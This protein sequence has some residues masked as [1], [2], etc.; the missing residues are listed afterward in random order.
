MLLSQFKINIYTIII[1]I[2]YSQIIRCGDLDSYPLLHE[3]ILSSNSLYSIEDDAIGRLEILKVLYL[4]HNLLKN[5]PISLPGNLLKLYL[6]NNLLTDIN[7]R[8]LEQLYN[9]ELLDLSGNQLSYIAALPLPKLQVLNLRSTS[10]LSLSQSLVRTS[11]ILRDLY[12]ENNPIKCAD[13]LGIAE[14]ATPCREE[15]LF[16]GD[17]GEV[18]DEG[19]SSEVAAGNGVNSNYYHQFLMQNH[20][21]KCRHLRRSMV[22]R[23]AGIKCTNNNMKLNNGLESKE[24]DRNNSETQSN[25]MKLFDQHQSNKVPN[26]ATRLMTT[27]AVVTPQEAKYSILPKAIR[28]NDND[29]KIEIHTATTSIPPTDRSITNAATTITSSTTTT[30]IPTDSPRS[31]EPEK[32]MTSSQ[33][34]FTT[35]TITH[36]QDTTPHPSTA[37][38]PLAGKGA[39]SPPPQLHL[40]NHNIAKPLNLNQRKYLTQNATTTKYYHKKKNVATTDKKSLMKT[41]KMRKE[42]NDDVLSHEIPAVPMTPRGPK[43]SITSGTPAKRSDGAIKEI[44]NISIKSFSTHRTTAPKDGSVATDKGKSRMNATAAHHA[45]PKRVTHINHNNFETKLDMMNEKDFMIMNSV[46]SNPANGGSHSTGGGSTRIE[47]NNSTSGSSNLVKYEKLNDLRSEQK[48]INHPG[49]FMVIGVTIGIII[50]LG[51]IHLY[52]CRKPYAGHHQHPDCNNLTTPS[53]SA[54][55]DALR[56]EVLNPSQHPLQQQLELQQLHRQQHRSLFYH[57]PPSPSPTNITIERW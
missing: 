13:L 7:V 53:H 49:L 48:H 11:P 34:D 33:S 51:L 50:T 56:L 3:L 12:L 38:Q 27:T 57:P 9:L 2:F 20:F 42:T 44:A 23:P 46:N 1:R 39:V 54:H 25:L 22:K 21:A 43:H 8:Q 52:R 36:N 31:H 32:P 10:L 28:A 30:T 41:L 35:A 45:A 18:D 29:A 16:D 24:N 15:K 40:E 37:A 5:L 19:D 6:N 17:N 47:N 26:E 14:W 55:S 4:D